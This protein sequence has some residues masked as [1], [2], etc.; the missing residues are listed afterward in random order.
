MGETF[1]AKKKIISSPRYSGYL[2]LAEGFVFESTMYRQF[3]KDAS[4]TNHGINYFEFQTSCANGVTAPCER[5]TCKWMRRLNH[6]EK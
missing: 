3:Y 1:V 6:G 4:R 5:D 2:K